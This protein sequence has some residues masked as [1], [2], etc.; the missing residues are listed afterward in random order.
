MEI[1][2]KV[3]PHKEQRYDTVGD[4]WLDSKGVMQFRVSAMGN[5]LY[6]QAVFLHE[7]VEWSLTQARGITEQSITNFDEMFET[8]RKIAPNVIGDQEPGHMV[9]APYHA[10][11]V[12]AEKLERQFTEEH[13]LDWKDYEN[14]VEGL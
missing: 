5:P 6:E 2:F 1:N 14:N 13:G 3:I 4:Y 8:V 11:H 9:S 7:F 10:E 12:F